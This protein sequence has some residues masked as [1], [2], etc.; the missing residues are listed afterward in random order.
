MNVN[1]KKQ[2]VLQRSGKPIRPRIRHAFTLI[3]LLVVIAITTIILALLFAPLL[4]GFNFTRRARAISAAQD[5]ARTGLALLRR[6]LS[7][8]AYIFDNT[9]TPVNLPLQ[10][11]QAGDNYRLPFSLFDYANGTATVNPAAPFTPAL[12]F[13]KIDLVLPARDKSQN[14]VEDPTTGST[15]NPL[16]GSVGTNVRFPLAPGT[17]VVRYFVGLRRNLQADGK[18]AYYE[19][20]YEFPRTDNEFNPFILYR[21]E[22]ESRDPLLFNTN[23][24]NNSAPNSGGF[25]DP[26]FFYNTELRAANGSTYAENW[27]RAAQPVIDNQNLDLL[28]VRRTDIRAINIQ[29]PFFTTVN[30]APTTVVADTATPGFLSSDASEAPGAV[31]SLYTTK[32][33]QW[34]LPYTVTFYRGSTRNGP[35][36]GKLSVRVYASDPDP[37]TGVRSLVVE[38]TGA[39]LAPA[40]NSL[41]PDTFYTSISPTTQR[42]FV[43]TPGLTFLLDPARGRIETGFPPLAGDTA[44][45]PLLDKGG[46]PSPMVPNSTGPYVNVGELIPTVFRINTR[47]PDAG[48]VDANGAT[49]PAN[50]GFLNI[51][52]LTNQQAN[53]LP[54]VENAGFS[55]GRNYY[56]QSTINN[57]LTLLPDAGQFP[58]PRAI[59]GHLLIAPGTE[60]VLGPSSTYTTGGASENVS[61]FR[62]PTFSDPTMAQTV[63]FQNAAITPPVYRDFT[64]SNPSYYFD[65]DLPPTDML[66]FASQPATQ[67]GSNSGVPGVPALTTGATGA[68]KEL[69]VTYLWQNNYARKYRATDAPVDVPVGTPLDAEGRSNIS[70]EPGSFNRVAGAPEPDVVKV[71]YSTRSVLAIT[72][73][74]R[75]YDSGSGEAQFI[76]LAD[77]IQINNVGR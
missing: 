2:M 46:V 60:R 15:I 75:V 5:S 57:A 26:N 20:Q 9:N 63:F 50:Q 47:R 41:S 71:D 13:T 55:P 51:R 22:F 14:Q 45:Q 67:P 35:A 69:R 6:E 24:Y 43:K 31:P 33:S 12:L 39:G 36:A 25:N 19:N 10:K 66:R 48:T 34:T 23:D 73:G 37:A 76:Q 18:P 44:G 68:Q 59:F 30:F 77:K 52:L 29:N 61:Y 72:V 56:L 16:T 38:P 58:S 74:A 53:E 1:D 3:E 17:R 4:Q 70:A 8:A 7:Q 62:L 27:A 28:V 54:V 65:Y 42:I 21:A 40:A 11:D 49:V 32:Y 64:I